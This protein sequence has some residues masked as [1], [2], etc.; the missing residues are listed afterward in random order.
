MIKKNDVILCEI[1]DVTNMGYGVAKQ[2]GQAIFVRGT[3]T[4]DI[5]SAKII[6]TFPT[7]SI[8]IPNEFSRLSEYRCENDCPVFPACGGCA[9][10]HIDYEYE[11]QIKQ[12][13]VK[14]C[15]FKEGIDAVVHSVISKKTT[16]YRNKVQYPVAT[17]KEGKL[18]LGFYSEYSHR[19]VNSVG[20]FTE[21]VAFKDVKNEITYA[22]NKMGYTSYD[23]KTGKGLL[24][25]VFLRSNREGR[26]HACFVINGEKLPGSDILCETLFE[27]CPELVGISV[28]INQSDTNV[29]LGDETRLIRG[30]D[31]LTDSILGKTFE[32]SPKSFWQIN[33]DTTEALYSK[34][35]ELL[36]LNGSECVL[37]LYCGIGS[38]GISVCD[39]EANLVGVEIVSEAV[40]NA[41]KNASINGFENAVFVC[42]D[43]FVGVSEC[44]KRFGRVDAV[45]VDPPRK[46]VSAQVID[47]IVSSGAN[48]VLYISCNP[49][50]LARDVAVFS[51]KGYV[52]GDVYPFD[53]FPRTG[54]VETVVLLS[55]E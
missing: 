36:A 35:K 1:T 52:H 5:L 45:I 7:Y 48:K 24:R 14:G 22:I 34:G 10:R 41:K 54:H 12:N 11:K 29:I 6:K 49:A 13:F 33:P 30:S 53:M 32:I 17:D 44:K 46:G 20:C 23:E 47:E 2:E 31:I 27:R 16:H 51:K 4:G 38:I 43:A 40:D 21:D 28:N 55:R 26:V 9:Y 18:Y 50:T 39:R 42:G 19:A 25:H 8:A 3:V 15:F 37:D